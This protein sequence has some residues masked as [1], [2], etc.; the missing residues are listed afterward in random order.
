MALFHDGNFY[1]NNTVIP[2]DEIGEGAMALLCFTNNLDCCGEPPRRFGE[3]Y[4]PNGSSVGRQSESSIYRDRGPSVVRLNLRNHSTSLT[5]V[6]H[7]EIPDMNGTNQSIYIGLYPVNKG[8]LRI[9][10]NS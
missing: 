2:M 7:C 1:A 8:I 9:M 5:G 10:L 4:F 3:W 6:F